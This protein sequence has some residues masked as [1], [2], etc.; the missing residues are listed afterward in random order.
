M[1]KVSRYKT[2]WVKSIEN[3]WA[4]GDFQLFPWFLCI[5]IGYFFSTGLPKNQ[6]GEILANL[7]DL[8]L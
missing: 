7:A 8:F 4:M 5:L 3:I 6:A 2:L 1:S